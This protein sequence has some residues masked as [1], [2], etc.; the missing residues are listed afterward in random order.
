MLRN[1]TIIILALSYSLTAQ[2]II[3]THYTIAFS[4]N[5]FYG[6]NKIDTRAIINV[7]GK[8]LVAE[9]DKNAEGGSIIIK[10]KSE[11]KSSIESGV[12]AFVLF[13]SEYIENKSLGTLIP[14][15]SVMIDGKVGFKYQII[16]NINSGITNISG[17]RNKSMSLLGDN[18]ESPTLQWLTALLKESKLGSPNDFFSEISMELKANTTIL[19]VFFNKFDACLTTSNSF[20]VAK[21]LNPQITKQMKIIETSPRLLSGII[22]FNK[23]ILGTKK[24]T[25]LVKAIENLHLNYYGR[26]LLDLYFIDK[27]VPYK[28]EHLISINNMLHQVKEKH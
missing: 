14:R 19:S 4:D 11:L 28:E 27:M 8:K 26:Q 16:T 12:D 13:S 18:E 25:V 17:L 9:Y 1:L 24:E 22:C 5:T 21:E 3:D 15:Y 10:V 23:S 7:L 2:N 6:V 20:E